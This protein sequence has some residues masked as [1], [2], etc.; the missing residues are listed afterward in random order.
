MNSKRMFQ[1][2]KKTTLENRNNE[3]NFDSKILNGFNSDPN[4]T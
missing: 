4:Y 1:D 3:F 2:K